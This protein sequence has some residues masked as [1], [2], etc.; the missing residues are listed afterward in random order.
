MSEAIVYDAYIRTGENGG[1]TALLLDLLGCYAHGAS[2]GEALARLREVIPTYYEWLSRHDEYTPIVQGPFDVQLKQALHASPT[3]GATGGVFFEGD[4]QPVTNEDLDWALAILGWAFDDL[5]ALAHSVTPDRLAQTN[6]AGWSPKDLLI[7]TA[8]AQ[9][10][11]LTHL[12]PSHQPINT[13]TA[14]P[15]GDAL[16]QVNWTRQMTLDRLRATNDD[17]RASVHD[18]SNGE[19]WSLRKLLRRSVLLIREATER[20]EMA[21]Q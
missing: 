3:M 19:R 15:S 16:S 8:Q 21:V 9:L 1:Y 10:N 13:P 6:A 20:L 12:A 2:E 5:L 14:L 18:D 4:A 17:E 7:H 11:L